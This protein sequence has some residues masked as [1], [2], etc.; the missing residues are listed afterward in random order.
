M[1]VNVDTWLESIRQAVRG[2]ADEKLQH[3]AWLGLGPEESSPG[4]MFNQFDD[5]ALEEFLKRNDVGLDARQR[6]AGARL[7]MLMRQLSDATP[8]MIDQEIN[9]AD[10]LNDPRLVKC[11]E[12]AAEFLEL[13]KDTVSVKPH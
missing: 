8:T 6:E 5:A 12:A 13:L 1:A 3:R 7:V 10:F 4:E 2:I 11:R 9:P